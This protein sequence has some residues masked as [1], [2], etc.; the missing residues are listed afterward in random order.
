MEKEG[1][2]LYSERQVGFGTAGKKVRGSICNIRGWKKQGSFAGRV[3]HKVVRAWQKLMF[4]KSS[5]LLQP[6]DD[7]KV[8]C[9]GNE[10]W[11]FCDLSGRSKEV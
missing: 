4:L 3:F 7:C 6:G 10:S 9:S 11:A 2:W 1:H 8:G 5:S